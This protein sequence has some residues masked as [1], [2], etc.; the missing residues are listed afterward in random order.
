[1]GLQ[2]SCGDVLEQTR[3]FPDNTFDAVF[4]DPPYGL[5]KTPDMTELLTHWLNGKEYDTGGGFMGKTW[6][7]VPG[8][9]VWREL[10]RVAKPGAYLLAFGGT[11]TADLLSIAIR[12]AG[13]QRWD[14]IMYVFGSGFPKSYNIGNVVESFAGYGSALKPSFEPI[15]CFRKTVDQTYAHNA[16]AHG[17]GG[18]NIDECRVPIT[19][20]A[21]MARNN[22]P[23]D[24]GWKNSSGGANHAALHGEPAG[25]WPANLL[26]GYPEDEYMLRS[27]ITAEQKIELYNWMAENT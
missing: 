23:G 16:L 10:Y 20:G 5:G 21:T 24:N 1:M 6:D 18:L 22:K 19:D 15:L 14:E 13:W 12:L 7:V 9:A 11:R 3:Q 2:V 4:C 17:C 8:P 27:D 26:T 25:R